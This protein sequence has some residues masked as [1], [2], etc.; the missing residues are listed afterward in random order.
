M[1]NWN[2]PKAVCKRIRLL[3]DEDVARIQSLEI[4]TKD[5]WMD[6]SGGVWISTHKTLSGGYMSSL[7]PKPRPVKR[8]LLPA[9]SPP[10]EDETLVVGALFGEAA[11]WKEKEMPQ[12]VDVTG[13]T[14][15]KIQQLVKASGRKSLTKRELIA[16]VLYKLQTTAL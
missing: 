11:E 2:D 1:Q 9:G 7:V 16:F 15:E 4:Y 3:R 5:A 6:L 12:V 13:M 10:L 14:Q 8:I